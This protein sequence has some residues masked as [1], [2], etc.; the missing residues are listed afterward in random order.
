M[1]TGFPSR[2]QAVLGGMVVA[3][4][5]AIEVVQNQQ[6]SLSEPLS[7]L[8]LFAAVAVAAVVGGSVVGIVSG[9]IG[10][11]HV[12]YS[13]VAGHPAAEF[14]SG[15]LPTVLGMA[16]FVGSGLLLSRLRDIYGLHVPR[17]REAELEAALRDRTAEFAESEKALAES[18]ARY[19]NLVELSPDAVM[20]A[21]IDDTIMFCNPA[22]VRL[23]GAEGPGAVVGR[24]AMGLIPADEVPAAIARRA[25]VFRGE[26]VHLNES[27]LRRFD[28]SWIDVERT[29]GA[30]SWHGE[31]A[32]LLIVRDIAERKERESQFQLISHQ[33]HR[34]S[35]RLQEREA[36][37]QAF[38]EHS[39]SA[40]LIKD[41]DSRYLV[42]NRRWQDWFNPEGDEF[43]GKTAF[44]FYPD[45]HALRVAG[46]EA[47][48]LASGGT[49]E[50]E[51]ETTFADG[52]RHTML[53]QNFPIFDPQGN[54]IG[55]GG[56]NT[57]ISRR[58]R[59]EAALEEAKEEAEIAN[60]TKSEFLANMSHELRTPL[61]AI[62]GFSDV[63]G[64]Q[65]FG[66]VGDSKYV[67][68]ARDI[69]D[70]G[71][72]LLKITNDILDLSKIEAG[73]AKLLEEYVDVS[74]LISSCVVL[75]RDRVQVGQLQLVVEAED[76][77]PGLLADARMMKQILI[78]L[79]SNAI[80]FTPPSGTVKLRV[81]ADREEGL[82][83]EIADTGIGIDS[84]DISTVLEPFEQ[85]QSNLSR[86]FDGTGL[87]LP[88][89]KSL[90]EMH[91]GRITLESELG[92]GTTV[93]VRFPPDRL[94]VSDAAANEPDRMARGL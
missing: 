5:L 79:L 22:L 60:R 76:N 30:I 52:T 67:E 38:I 84:A 12:L 39:P 73:H 87:G 71:Q 75:V 78:N 72:H 41:L 4:A 90:V 16:L 25:A 63:I 93:M 11:A 94:V 62:I 80:K 50:V 20:V 37:L 46:S 69:N 28:G 21:D 51:T 58:K 9:A 19:L 33:L 77:L 61:N 3:V 81:A 23:L 56:I 68:Y 92:A 47:E 91:G 88:L 32:V 31:P 43:V 53:L 35:L 13:A 1:G 65:Q 14:A 48:A 85:V 2:Q 44:D 24:K 57:D 34:A 54:V 36:W 89:A 55:L 27:R 49:I 26:H 42:A 70:A 40:I 8:V 64:R 17:P 10:A 15:P 29:I 59:V 7:L 82:A 86:R 6:Q 66:P 18:D 74:Q 45:D 83:F